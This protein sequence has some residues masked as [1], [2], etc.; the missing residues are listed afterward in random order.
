MSKRQVL[1]ILGIWIMIF[2]FISF[3]AWLDKMSSL[4]VGA[5]IVL[6]SLSMK[7]RE[8]PI[9]QDQAPY[10]ERNNGS[11]ATTSTQKTTQQSSPRVVP[12][13]DGMINKTDLPNIPS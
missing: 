6:I 3:P 11:T 9:V 12:G 1:I 2:L 7:P 8:R 10:T 5:L 13:V 4:I